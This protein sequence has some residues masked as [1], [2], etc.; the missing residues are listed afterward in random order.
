MSTI[1]NAVQVMVDDLVA[2]MASDA[3]LT[4]EEQSMV[5]EAIAL[6]S[7]STKLETALIA[8][9]EKHLGTATSALDSAKVSLQENADYLKLL[10][11]INEIKTSFGNIKTGLDN[12]LGNLPAVMREGAPATPALAFNWNGADLFYLTKGGRTDTKGISQ[13]LPQTVVSLFDDDEKCFYAYIGFGSGTDYLSHDCTV[14]VDAQG[15]RSGIKATKKRISGN[16]SESFQFMKTYAGVRLAKMTSTSLKFFDVMPLLTLADGSIPLSGGRIYQEPDTLNF[17]SYSQGHA[18]HTV[19][20]DEAKQYLTKPD[21]DKNFLVEAN[22]NDWAEQ[23]N[24]ILFLQGGGCSGKSGQESLKSAPHGGSE[25]PFS[26][27]YISDACHRILINN[28]YVS[29]K[30]GSTTAEVIAWGPSNNSFYSN[31]DGST[32]P[33]PAPHVFQCSAYYEDSQNT[34][35]LSF[36]SQFGAAQRLYGNKSSM[37]PIYTPVLVA[38]SPYH[39]LAI[40][41]LGNCNYYTS[42]TSYYSQK[43]VVRAF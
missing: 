14:K 7:K 36:N 2:K 17:W 38:V 34:R 4:A 3:P 15:N 22:F 25:E 43:T 16:A 13:S 33:F 41:S 27:N 21:T 31:T 18:Q 35:C 26:S 5:A 23:Q 19:W 11:Q 40:L 32:R 42:T 39:R 37:R 28:R 10:P 24:F 20:D 1:S 9:A 29:G 30:V 12:T 6:L 8:V